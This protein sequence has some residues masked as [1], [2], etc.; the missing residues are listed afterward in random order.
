MHNFVKKMP[1]NCQTVVKKCQKVDKKMLKS[2]YKVVKKL[3]KVPSK[4]YL[5]LKWGCRVGGEN[6]RSKAFGVSVSDR[7]KAKR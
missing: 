7:P 5:K 2:C 4:I 1:K 3:S 6:S